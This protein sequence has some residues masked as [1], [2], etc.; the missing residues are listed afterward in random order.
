MAF[1][2]RT[3]SVVLLSGGKFIALLTRGELSRRLGDRR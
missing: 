2:V 3:P 1:D